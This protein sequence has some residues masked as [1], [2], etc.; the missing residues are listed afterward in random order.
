MTN[1][2][3]IL[4]QI[5]QELKEI[6][7]IVKFVKSVPDL[8]EANDYSLFILSGPKSRPVFERMFGEVNRMPDGCDTE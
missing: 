4:R 7:Q 3:S 5:L 2:E 1:E 8:K 6:K